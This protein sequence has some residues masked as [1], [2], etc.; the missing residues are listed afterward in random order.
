[1]QVPVSLKIRDGLHALTRKFVTEILVSSLTT[2]LVMALFP[3]MMKPAS[4]FARND[5]RLASVQ[6]S[7]AGGETS[8]ALD[9]FMERVALSHISGLKT[10]PVAVSQEAIVAVSKPTTDTGTP[11]PPLA[12]AAPRHERASSSKLHVAANVLKVLPPVQPP[13]ATIESPVVSTP[14]N[15]VSVPMKAEPLPPLRYGMHL[16]ADLGNIISVSGTRVV[17]SVASVGDTLTSLVKK[18]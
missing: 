14:V 7:P 8:E 4:L 16:V 5:E 2:L 11:F 12:A 15:V 3:N 17:E 18:L 9:D 10:R 1:M 13:V 6:G